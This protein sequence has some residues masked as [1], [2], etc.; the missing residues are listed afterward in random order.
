MSGIS[1]MLAK[2]NHKS[3]P[4]KG[5]IFERKLDGER[6]IAIKKEKNVNLYSRYGKNLNIS[7]PEIQEAL[8]KQKKD[9]IIDGEIV[10]FEK[11][12]T[13]FSKLQPRMH[14]KSREKAKA[15]GVKV[16][17]YVF[18]ILKSENKNIKVYP[19][20]KRKKILRK[21]VSFGGLVRFLEHI[22]KNGKKYYRAACKKHWEGLI[23]KKI[24]SKYKPNLRSS[25]WLKLKC[26]NEQEFV[27]GGFT[28]PEGKRVGFGAL[29]L[30]YY[31]GEKLKYCGKVGTGKGFTENFLKTLSNKL[32]RFEIKKSPFSEKI[33]TKN[34]HW[35]SPKMVVQIAF[36]EW[37]KDKKLRHPRFLG[38]RRGKKAKEVVKE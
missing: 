22:E 29:L 6:C 5:W 10:A 1:P 37:T 33:K 20:I 18:D 21:T 15:T 12:E 36:T 32:K 3:F 19:L 13:S 27:V 4:K 35:T 7:Y 8:R 16:Y 24:N 9:F 2:L 11:G 23:A 38:F 34:I 31:K 25:D 26:E 14:L 17:Y 28:K 30:G